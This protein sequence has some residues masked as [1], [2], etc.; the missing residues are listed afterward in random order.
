MSPLRWEDDAYILKAAE[1]DS[2]FQ[3]LLLDDRIFPRRDLPALA[4]TARSVCH[5]RV[6]SQ[7]PVLELPEDV[8]RTQLYDFSV[9]DQDWFNQ[10]KLF[11]IAAAAY[12]NGTFYQ[13]VP[14]ELRLNVPD[15]EGGSRDRE[16]VVAVRMGSECMTWAGTK[17]Y[18]MVHFTHKGGHV[19]G[20]KD[21]GRWILQ[22][23][24][25]YLNE[26]D[27][28]HLEGDVQV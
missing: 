22:H 9:N 13:N 5:W 15:L 17:C 11:K 26:T 21:R 25:E 18:H 1:D 12:P 3:R 10:W 14:P 2:V 7:Q 28:E 8:V 16:K 20:H 27:I 6:T 19:S 4:K 24:R 23:Y